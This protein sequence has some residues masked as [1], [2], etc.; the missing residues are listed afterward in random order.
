MT[1]L[2]LYGRRVA[3]LDRLPGAVC[4]LLKPLAP[5]AQESLARRSGLLEKLVPVHA[6]L[7]L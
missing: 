4:A 7:V 1:Q 5:A 6:R 3:A 2:L